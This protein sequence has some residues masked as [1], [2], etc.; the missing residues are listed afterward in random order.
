MSF[1]VFMQYVLPHRLLS[2]L[3]RQVAYSRWQ[4]L[5]DWLIRLAIRTFDID[6]AEAAD[7]NPRNYPSFNAFFTRAPGRSARASP[8]PIPPPC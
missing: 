1:A 2:A 6:V 7:P 8:I 3:A 4:P 5:K